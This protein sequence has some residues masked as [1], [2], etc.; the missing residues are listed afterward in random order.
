MKRSRENIFRVKLSKK[1]EKFLDKLPQRDR[2]RVISALRTLRENPFSLDIKNLEGT[3]FHRVRV[4]KT[5][6]IIVYI[7][8]ETKTIAVLRI[9]KRERVYN[10]L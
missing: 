4:G 5:F 3:E 1:A 2:E 10:R 7:D 8:W 9:D 6:R